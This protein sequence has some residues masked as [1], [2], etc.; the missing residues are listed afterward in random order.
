MNTET[1]LETNLKLLKSDLES[2]NDFN[3]PGI[4][5]GEPPFSPIT[6]ALIENEINHLEKE[7]KF[8]AKYFPEHK[9][10][11]IRELTNINSHNDAVL[12]LAQ[13]LNNRRG[14]TAMAGVFSIHEAYGHMPQ[15]LVTIR[16]A[17]L[18]QLLEIADNTF[19]NSE[20]IRG[21]F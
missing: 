6:K 9:I 21:A 1:H 7:N 8:A 15:E 19:A 3:T 4:C 16:N 5:D 18:K 20:Q 12:V 17:L 11:S 10:E 2:V 13:V 14:L